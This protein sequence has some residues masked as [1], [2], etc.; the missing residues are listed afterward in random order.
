MPLYAPHLHR[1]PIGNGKVVP[2]GPVEIDWTNPLT[3]GLV[4]AFLPG[5]SGT[6]D[7]T[8]NLRSVPA[9]GTPS[10]SEVGPYVF[11]VVGDPTSVPPIQRVS[12]I[13]QPYTFMVAA[14]NFAGVGNFATMGG[15]AYSE[16]FSA[17]YFVLQFLNN[18]DYASY[19]V[20]NNGTGQNHVAAVPGIGNVQRS[21]AFAGTNGD[22]GVFNSGT[23][24][25]Y[26][27][28]VFAAAAN[29]MG[30]LYYTPTSSWY[31]GGL[32]TALWMRQLSAA[33]IAAVDNAP[34]TMFRPVA[35]RSRTKV[36][37]SSASRPRITMIA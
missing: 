33:E 16:P 20:S 37:G 30:A 17:P 22:P 8:R 4:A 3:N 11:G 14:R 32:L 15:T 36:L 26:A 29:S 24:T 10:L 27:D 1:S 23:G 25:V 21:L 13:G 9:S 35:S 18:G 6:F 19:D 28:G 31:P 34:F 5:V 2:T 12:A 7:Y